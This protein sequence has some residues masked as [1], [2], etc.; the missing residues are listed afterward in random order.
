MSQTQPNSKHTLVKFGGSSLASPNAWKLVFGHIR[1]S[2]Q[3]QPL[4]VV[5]SALGK[6][7][8]ALVGCIQEATLGKR[9]EVEQK[10]NE[11]WATHKRIALASLDLILAKNLE[12]RP[13][14][15]T[16]IDDFLASLHQ[17]A[18]LLCDKL[19]HHPSPMSSSYGDAML[20][21]GERATSQI[22]QWVLDVAG[23]PSVWID[24]RDIII[25]D[26]TFG[27]AK[28]DQVRTQHALRQHPSL[29]TFWSAVQKPQEPLQKPPQ[30]R[31]DEQPLRKEI[32]IPVI[33]GFMGRSLSGFPTTLGFEGSDLTTTLLAEASV[34]ERVTIFTDVDGIMTTDPRVV[35]HAKHIPALSYNEAEDLAMGGA[36]VLHPQTLKPVIESKIP[37]HVRNT[38]RPDHPGTII[39]PQ[40]AK[41]THAPFVEG[42]KAVAM[43]L[44]QK[45]DDTNETDDTAV[46]TFIHATD[47]G[48][49]LLRQWS[50]AYD[51][52]LHVD[53]HGWHLYLASLAVTKSVTKS[54]PTPASE[55][56][57]PSEPPFALSL[58]AIHDI[59]FP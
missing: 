36:R 41:T 50:E 45:R 12:Q 28:P 56:R 10:L 7:T 39:G 15:E 54:D 37:V 35:P 11:I 16:Q 4:I 25:T 53:A 13:R 27:A 38:F 5:V 30:E 51:L 1:E 8:R 22:F 32:P 20:S 21:F 19:H 43:T 47:E 46:L 52:K 17:E 23:Y 29:S 31:P 18:M 33:G 58:P 26:E 59:F 57:Q 42:W 44:K 14:L 40:H 48:Q 49:A 34:A 9:E 3:K 55:E 2:Y 6:T 24:A